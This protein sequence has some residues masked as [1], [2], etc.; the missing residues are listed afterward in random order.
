MSRRKAGEALYNHQDVVDRG[1]PPNGDIGGTK[2]SQDTAAGLYNADDSR[3]ATKT[4]LNTYINQNFKAQKKQDNYY[5]NT[6]T[7]DYSGD[8]SRAFNPQKMQQMIFDSP[9]ASRDRSQVRMDNIFGD[10]RKFNP[11]DFAMPKPG[12]EIESN[13]EEIAED[14]MGEIK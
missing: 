1:G 7:F 10:F 11:V 12:K 5:K 14:Y 9:Y 13:V 2:V 6:G 4:F 8:E 3:G